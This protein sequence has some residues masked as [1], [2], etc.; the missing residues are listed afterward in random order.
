MEHKLIMSSLEWVSFSINVATM[1]AALG[2][3]TFSHQVHPDHP[4]LY[5]SRVTL[6]G[7]ILRLIGL[8]SLTTIAIYLILLVGISALIGI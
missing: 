2:Y 3:A 4:S 8:F 1:I 5:R 6:I 7:R